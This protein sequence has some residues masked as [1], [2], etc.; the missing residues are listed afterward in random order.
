MV[1]S[2]DSTWAPWPIIHIKVCID[3]ELN[4]AIPRL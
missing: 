2:N 4:K 3:I 1:I